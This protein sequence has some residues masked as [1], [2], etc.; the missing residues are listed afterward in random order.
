[1]HDRLI[2]SAR[3]VRAYAGSDVSRH[4]TEM[5]DTLAQSYCMDLVNVSVE[6]LIPLQAAIKQVY[7]IRKV[8]E[9]EGID[10]PKI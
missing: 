1:M 3:Q 4:L 5:L 10:V 9:N 2:E 8:V 7:A 6:R